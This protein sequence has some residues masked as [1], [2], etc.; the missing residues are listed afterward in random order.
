MDSQPHGTGWRSLLLFIFSVSGMLFTILAAIS[1]LVMV[2]VNENALAEI[3]EV[4][5]SPLATILAASALFSFGLL[6]APAA[7]LSLQRLRGRKMEALNLPALRPWA[8]VAILCLWALVMIFAT[9]SYNSRGANWYVPLLHFLSI[10]L[11]IYIIIRIGVNRIPLGSSQ[12]AWGVF[13][14]GMTLSPTLSAIAEIALVGLGILVFA[15]YMGLN[16]DKMNNIE[17]LINQ[18]ENAPD[19]ESIIYLIRPLLQNPLTLLLALMFLS[20]FVPIIEELAKSVGIWLVADR[21]TSPAQ[22]FA[23]GILSGAGFALAESLFASLT[24]DDA[25]A[26]TLG[27]RAVSG[28]MHMLATGLAGWG[29]AYA[30][31]EKRYFRMAGM[32]LLAILLHGVWN[33]GAVLTVAGG[34]RLSLALPEIDTF[35]TLLT[36][37]GIGVITVLIGSMFVAL[38]LIN[39]TLRTPYQPPP[40]PMEIGDESSFSPPEEL[41]SKAGVK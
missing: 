28:G 33:A 5:A 38:F 7:W 39:R 1:L 14:S 25:W 26:L 36:L 40:F 11:P 35:G 18:I 21:L 9:L 22:G 2:T 23:L 12:R 3:S 8:W 24:P 30:R 13:G 6:L 31:L 27:M 37:G 19:L 29:I 32:M 41:D 4:N 16:P 34:L 20:V 10:A 15:V 17:R